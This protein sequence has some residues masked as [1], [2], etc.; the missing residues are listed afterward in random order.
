[1]LLGGWAAVHRGSARLGQK[2]KCGCSE[3]GACPGQAWGR[4]RPYNP[5]VPSGVT[6]HHAKSWDDSK[7]G[8]PGEHP[9]LLSVILLRHTSKNQNFAWK[10]VTDK[11]G[12]SK[13]NCT[14]KQS[15]AAAPVRSQGWS[16]SQG[17]F[18]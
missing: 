9:R 5:Q 2:E 16:P 12:H 14:E 8:R 3:Q 1:M 11:Q 6:R 13:S 18:S 17:R 4:V 15:A 7:R 10:M